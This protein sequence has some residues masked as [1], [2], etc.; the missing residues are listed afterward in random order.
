MTPAP[1]PPENPVMLFRPLGETPCSVLGL[2]TGM[3]CSVS[4]GLSNAT[5]QR[6]LETAAESGI[7][8][9]DTADSYAQ[10]DCESFRGGALRGR[11]DR[12]LITTKAGYQF[13]ALGGLARLVKPLAK[14][15]VQ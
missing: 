5:R 11:R 3:L 6:L 15:V 13:A 14:A 12:F 8:L 9:L 1:H 7:N 10:G 4:A 2:G